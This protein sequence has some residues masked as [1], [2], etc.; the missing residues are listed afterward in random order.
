[1]LLINSIII[2]GHVPEGYVHVYNVSIYVITYRCMLCKQ[3]FSTLYYCCL[4]VLRVTT[5]RKGVWHLSGIV[6]V[7]VLQPQSIEYTPHTFRVHMSLL[8]T[9]STNLIIMQT[10]VGRYRPCT[11]VYNN[12]LCTCIVWVRYTCFTRTLIHNKIKNICYRIRRCA[13]T[14]L[15]GLDY[16]WCCLPC[17]R[18][19]VN[20]YS[21][22]KKKI[23]VNIQNVTINIFCNCIC[24]VQRIMLP[25]ECEYI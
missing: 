21:S 16:M 1:M 6:C 9:C 23:S 20:V 2:R 17:K 22:L 25:E 4:Y 15:Y 10:G 19:S 14:H 8:I 11:Y 7:Y 24:N 18:K 12:N 3:P 13:L 5:F